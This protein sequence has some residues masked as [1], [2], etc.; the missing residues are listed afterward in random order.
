MKAGDLTSL[1]VAIRKVFSSAIT[2]KQQHARIATV[3]I[4]SVHLFFEKLFIIIILIGIT[5]I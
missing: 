1:V 4:T 5:D 2:G 3:S